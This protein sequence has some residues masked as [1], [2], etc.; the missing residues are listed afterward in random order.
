MPGLM[1]PNSYP[2]RDPK[3]PNQVVGRIVNPVRYQEIGGLTGP[4]KLAKGNSMTVQKPT[5]V[6]AAHMST[7][8]N[9][10]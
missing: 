10:E 6:R 4:G 9:P 3:D 8:K 5:S 2:I 1:A 7:N